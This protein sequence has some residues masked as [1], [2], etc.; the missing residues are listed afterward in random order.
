MSEDMRPP[1]RYAVFGHPIGHSKSPR[2]HALFA[3]QTGQSIHYTAEDVPA[4]NFQKALECFIKAGGK[5][6]NCTVPL[7][8]LAW[9]VA[10]K[11]SERAG[12]AKAVNT[13][14]V[15]ENGLL[16]GDNTDGLGLLRDLTAN[17][18]IPLA[19]RKYFAAGRG[20]R[21]PGHPP[22]LAGRKTA[23]AGDRQPHGRQG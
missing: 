5:G 3:G 23:A 18:R 20:R 8:E 1:D 12:R 22:A 16:L 13:L 4:E 2:I 17:L 10:D 11:T 19:D 21:Q 15:G 7:K 6:L 9:R 14:S